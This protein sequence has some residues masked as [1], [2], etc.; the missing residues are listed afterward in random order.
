MSAAISV[1][2]VSKHYRLG[3][4]GGGTLHEDLSRWWARVRHK[5]DPLLRVTDAADGAAHG[6]LVWA[7]DDISFAVDPGEAV[8]IIGRNGAGKSTIL[9]I[10]SQVTAPSSG[11]VRMRGRVGSLLEVG[12][13]FH[14][15]LTGR[16]NI[17]LNGSIL[18]M[19]R[20]EITA[21]LDEIV[22]FAEIGAYVDTP[23]K[24]YSSG[25]YVRLAFAV[26]AHL[27]PEILIVDEVLAVGDYAFQQKCLGK[28]QDVAERGRTV[29]FVSHNMAS[30]RTMCTRA[31]LLSHGRVQ[32]DGRVDD[33]IRAYLPA[34]Q[35][36]VA[37]DLRDV[38]VRAGSGRAKFVAV[39]FADGEGRPSATFHV[40]DDLQVIITIQALEPLRTAILK[41]GI[42]TSEGVRVTTLV[43]HEDTNFDMGRLE[44]TAVIRATI[45]D[46]RFYPGTYHINLGLV[47]AGGEILDRLE[48]AAAFEVQQGGGRLG[49]ELGEG[50]VHVNAE[51]TREV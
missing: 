27:L 8:G 12:T 45:P 18:G 47:A 1:E 49:R 44:G 22:E 32:I 15:E 35:A 39:S 26:A 41:F 14:P 9:K 10:L 3:V 51:W 28:M 25:M 37:T 19:R 40:G 38:D 23:V 42:L 6:D 13:G 48:R 21:R 11:E 30:I 46:Q 17:Y 16:E 24:R 34:G 43:P 33:A 2:H 5:P 4:I 50:L 31:V 7:L 36:N 20:K 29:L